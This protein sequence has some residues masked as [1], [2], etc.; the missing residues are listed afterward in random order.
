MPIG[1]QKGKNFEIGFLSRSFCMERTWGWLAFGRLIYPL[2]EKPATILTE[3]MIFINLQR[4][5]FNFQWTTILWLGLNNAR[6][7]HGKGNIQLIQSGRW[8][9]LPKSRQLS[10]KYCLIQGNTLESPATDQCWAEPAATSQVKRVSSL[11]PGLP[12]LEIPWLSLCPTFTK[13]CCQRL[14]PFPALPQV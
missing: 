11:S 5:L 14:L 8:T 3:F 1:L 2:L 7:I 6:T 13:G 10:C 12:H 9:W 4:S